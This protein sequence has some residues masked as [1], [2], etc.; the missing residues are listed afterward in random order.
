MTVSHRQLPV[1]A[2]DLKGPERFTDATAAVDRLTELYETSVD[3]LREKFAETMTRGMPECRFRAYY[4]EIRFTSSSH[5]HVDSRMSFGHVPTPGTYVTTVTRPD[6]FRN[7]LIQQ[8][9]LLIGNHDLPVSIGPSATPIPC[10][11][12][13][14]TV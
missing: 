14:S 1:Q 13:L 8:I 4:P 6:L 3:F 11:P 9:G 7:Y 10:A 5:A 2:P 12:K